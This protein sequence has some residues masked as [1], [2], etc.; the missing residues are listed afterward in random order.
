[1]RAPG[2]VTQASTASFSGSLHETSILDCPAPRCDRP[3]GGRA[4]SVSSPSLFWEATIFALT[5]I[6]LLTAILGSLYRRA[7]ARAFWLGFAV[8][9]WGYVLTGEIPTEFRSPNSSQSPFLFSPYNEGQEPPLRALTR[10]LID[11]LRLNRRTLPKS[12]GEKIQ[13]LWGG[14]FY[15]SSVLEISNN[16]DNMYK[17]R[18]DSDPQG[19]YD[20]WVGT[21]RI[22]LGDMDRSYRIGEWLFTLLFSIVGALIACVLYATRK[23]NGPVI[24]PL[25]QRER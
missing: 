10:S 6:L 1:M 15:P 7:G 8:F 12:V 13:V 18:Y 3:A 9:G 16:A 4:R 23:P 22:K 2:P 14:T 11:I 25:P 19:T 20:E 17:I 21:G 24:P 5:L